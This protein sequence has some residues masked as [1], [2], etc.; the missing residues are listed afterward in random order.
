MNQR[1]MFCICLMF[2][3]AGCTLQGQPAPAVVTADAGQPF[4]LRWGQNARLADAK[5]DVT[6]AAIRVDGRCPTNIQCAEAM[7]VEVAV[8]I[9][10]TGQDVTSELVLSAHT[11]HDGNV[12]ASAPGTPS[13]SFGDYAVTLLSVTP[14]P[15]AKRKIE[16]AEYAI[17]LLVSEFADETSGTQ[18]P[19]PVPT[20]E[21][22]S[23]TP[24]LGE[25]FALKFGQSAVAGENSL[26]VTFEAVKNDS[27]CPADVTCVWS[28]VV[29]VRLSAEAP[30][31]PPE[32][33]VVGGVTDRDG[34]VLGPL[35]E[36]TGPTSWWVAGSTITLTRVEPYPAHA[37]QPTA[38]EEYVVSL[39]V[40]EGAAAVP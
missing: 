12:T 34:V 17:T 25:E 39:V 20:P 4:T 24:V 27:R 33:F 8:K 7:P 14:Y 11:D 36:A 32:S 35:M 19:N 1:V 22:S 21:K 28:G 10:E 6:F 15:D 40:T 37:N 29:N 5:L 9:H 31:H 2:L 13:A 38:H 30:G 16:N 18:A 3:L 26:R 23:A